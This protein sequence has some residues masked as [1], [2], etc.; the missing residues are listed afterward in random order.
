MN[1]YEIITTLFIH[2]EKVMFRRLRLPRA[3]ESQV[4]KMKNKALR[5]DRNAFD[6]IK[7]RWG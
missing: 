3:W 4:D 1:K 6:F 7:N 5:D 2:L